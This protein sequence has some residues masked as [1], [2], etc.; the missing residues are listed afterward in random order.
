MRR[1]E[2]EHEYRLRTVWS[3]MR[4]R[5]GNPKNANYGGRGITVCDEWA[6]FEAF[7]TWA[8]ANGYAPGLQ[9]DRADN[10]GGY[11]PENCRWVTPRENC[12][13]RRNTARVK[14]GGKTYLLTELASMNGVT[15]N[16][17][18]ARLKNGWTVEQAVSTPVRFKT[19]KRGETQQMVNSIEI[20]K[21]LIE[22]GR[23]MR[24]MADFLDL[25]Y[26]T[27]NMKVNNKRDMSLDEAEKI[28]EFLGIPDSE[29]RK[30]FFANSG[31]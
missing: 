5:C 7:Y 8:M 14:Y 27:V 29:F 9:I 22:I 26:P 2:R 12:N 31:R 6:D 28:Q 15:Y 16:A 17:L 24:E 3:N 11:S 13:N 19:G 10:N 4:Y 25:S 21:R 18:S 1:P 23:T 20:K 30:F